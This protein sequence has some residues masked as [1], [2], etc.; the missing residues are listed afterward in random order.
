MTYCVHHVPGRARFKLPQLQHD[1][2]Y[3]GEIEK[4][5]M[6]LDGVTGVE[7]N[8]RAWS[9]IVHYDVNANPLD[10]VA[11][12]IGAYRP[13]NGENGAGAHAVPSRVDHPNGHNAIG[14]P[15]MSRVVGQAIG[16]AIFATLVQ[17]TL[18][19]SLLSLLTGLR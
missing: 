11:R 18:D 12:Q 5:I 8:Q 17:R 3:A 16:Q 14:G 10:A 13:A 2:A 7:V 19:R 6:A 9:M 4:R 1:P 15:E